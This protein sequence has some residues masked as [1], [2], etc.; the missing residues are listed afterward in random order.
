MI[1]TYSSLY[2]LL[3]YEYFYLLASLLIYNCLVCQVDEKYTH[4]MVNQ[5]VDHFTPLHYMNNTDIDNSLAVEF[6]IE[7]INYYLIL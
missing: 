7:I 3:I 6:L 2:L 5:G 1:K 4:T